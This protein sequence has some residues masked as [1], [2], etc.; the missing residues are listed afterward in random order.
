MSDLFTQSVAG[1]SAPA[2]ASDLPATA[3]LHSAITPAEILE[4]L[5]LELMFRR[6]VYATKVAAGT[7]APAD[8]DRRIAIMERLRKQTENLAKNATFFRRCLTNRDVID[9]VLDILDR[10][11]KGEAIR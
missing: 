4:E 1:S 10:L 7:M 2:V 6:R 5:E 8:R 3:A 11:E 9:Q